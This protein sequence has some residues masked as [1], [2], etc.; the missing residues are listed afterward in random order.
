MAYKYSL[1]YFHQAVGV[2]QLYGTLRMLKSLQLEVVE[3][4]GNAQKT[5]K[6]AEEEVNYLVAFSMC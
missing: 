3:A 5:G 2:G 6:D 1:F 4:V